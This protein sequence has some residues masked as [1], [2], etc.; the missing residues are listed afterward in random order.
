MFSVSGN[1]DVV[2]S[3]AGVFTS[4]AQQM[5][6]ARRQCY[7]LSDNYHKTSLRDTLEKL[8]FQLQQQKAT[9]WWI[10]LPIQ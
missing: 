6:R 3:L 1:K 4:F 8:G 2:R 9:Q 10:L 7:Q 5:F